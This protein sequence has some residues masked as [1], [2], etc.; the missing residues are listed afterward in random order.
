MLSHYNM[1]AV[2]HA[3]LASV[4]CYQQEMFLSFLP[5]SHTLERTAGY[6][7][8]MMAGASVAHARS[9]PQLAE[10][11]QSIRPSVMIAVPRIFERV[12]TRILGQLETRSVLAR[13]LFHATVTIGWQCFRHRQGE[14]GWRPAF[15]VYPLL[16]KAVGD[17][18]TA[19]LGGRMR[20]AIS[21][22]ASLP[23]P[24]A[25]TFIG[26][27]LEILQGYGLT[28]TSPV[29]AVNRP[30]H[31]DPASVGEPCRGIEVR[32]GDQDELLVKSPGI[33]L[34]YWNDHAAT[35]RMIDAEGWLHTGDQARI[36]QG[37]I[38]ITGRI[39]DILV[40]SNGE[41]IPPAD[42]EAAICLD[43]LIDQALVVGEGKPY[44]SA[45]LVLNSDLWF[46]FA[47]EL[48][49]DPFSRDSLD[50]EALHRKVLARVRAQLHE[51][52]G[53]ARVRRV[54]LHLEP[55]TIEDGLV[56][57]TL[58]VKR[59][60]VLNQFAGQVEALYASA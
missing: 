7:L 3:S 13:L 51:F 24:V 23:L 36:D 37:R 60:R 25:R 41:K 54:A 28:E 53:Y 27:G 26:L 8:P 11:L 31:N 40:L 18:I 34:G 58:K 59:A 5:L 12:H 46:G 6:Y 15:L 48:G 2:A 44:L 52:P 49:L 29:I 45:L 47:R 43:P 20:Y 33:M 38:Y 10:D 56:T 30:G 57:P 39:K 55:W 21:G 4:D 1:L 14:T 32:V 42:M 35:A 22:G 50:D 9:I 19:R 17:K 16:K